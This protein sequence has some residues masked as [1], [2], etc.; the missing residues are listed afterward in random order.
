LLEALMAGVAQGDVAAKERLQSFL[1][2]RASKV[3]HRS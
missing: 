1:K 3:Q 2:G